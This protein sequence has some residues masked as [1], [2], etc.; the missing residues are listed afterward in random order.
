MYRTVNLVKNSR[1]CR[2][3]VEQMSANIAQTWQVPDQDPQD[4]PEE[5]DW[6]ADE[7]APHL[8]LCASLLKSN[9]QNGAVILIN[10]S[11]LCSFFVIN[12]KVTQPEISHA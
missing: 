6:E 10:V 3:Q 8:L 11:F 2:K 4:Q 1:L 12:T 5:K 9:E 7:A